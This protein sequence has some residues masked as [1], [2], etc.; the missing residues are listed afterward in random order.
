MKKCKIKMLGCFLS[1]SLIAAIFMNAPVLEVKAQ[2]HSAVVLHRHSGH[3]KANG[4][5]YQNAIL[6]KGNM[7]TINENVN[8]GAP[9]Q[10]VNAQQWKCVKGHIDQNSVGNG[11]YDFPHGIGCNNVVGKKTYYRCATC[12]NTNTNNISQCNIVNGYAVSCQ[13]G[14]DTIL[15]A[16]SGSVSHE[17]W[18]Q[19]LTANVSVNIQ[20]DSYVLSSEPFSWNGG[21]TSQT[22]F[23]IT[24]NGTYMFTVPGNDNATAATL[25]FVITSIDK[26][27]PVIG[28]VQLSSAE[29]NQTE[30]SV[31]VS[32]SDAASGISAAGYSWDGGSTWTDQS[33]RTFGA[34]GEYHIIVKDNAGNTSG[35]AF[36]IT[37]IKLP[38]QPVPTQA[39]PPAKPNPEPTKPTEQKPIVPPNVA[40]V[41]KPEEDSKEKSAGVTGTLKPS[42]TTG[43]SSKSNQHSISNNKN[44]NNSNKKI[45]Q[46]D[47]DLDNTQPKTSKNNITTL[48]RQETFHVPIKQE[49][50][51]TSQVDRT[52]LDVKELRLDENIDDLSS[53]KM[54]QQLIG[55]SNSSNWIASEMQRIV[56]VILGAFVCITTVLLWKKRKKA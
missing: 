4:G 10:I 12:Q 18:C 25:T 3:A 13:K 23:S 47:K 26:E 24:E 40:Q 42:G 1:L 35:Q 7:N 33:T 44:S 15:A 39:P 36:S 34:N 17:N 28:Q 16:I 29:P 9:G 45:T 56:I 52:M 19:Q 30:V 22:S 41:P 37:N 11:W 50:S 54:E 14:E 2:Q 27:A 38:V 49:N 46:K 51:N 5:C 8:C 53:M 55:A 6:C 31:T 21:K 32:A 48:E 20:N 43:T